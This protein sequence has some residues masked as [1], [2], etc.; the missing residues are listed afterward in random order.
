MYIIFMYIRSTITL[1]FY[2]YEILQNKIN[3]ILFRK[4]NIY[5]III[6]F[7]NVIHNLK[8]IYILK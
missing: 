4:F 8:N 3:N 1:I 5:S 7:S 2:V 6:F